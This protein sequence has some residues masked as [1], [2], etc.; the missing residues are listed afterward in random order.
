[1]GGHRVKLSLD[2]ANGPR[3]AITDER[4]QFMGDPVVDEKA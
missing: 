4:E 2:Q 3:K 1:M